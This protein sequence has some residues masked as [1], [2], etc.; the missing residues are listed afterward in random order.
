MTRIKKNTALV[1]VTVILFFTSAYISF[2]QRPTPSDFQQQAAQQAP[3]QGGQASQKAVFVPLSGLQLTSGQ[4]PSLIGY[5]NTI[6]T[7][8]ITI[9]AMLSVIF[10]AIAGVKYMSSDNIGTKESAKNDIWSCLVGLVLILGSVII[11]QV[12]NPC[13]LNFD[14]LRG[15]NS[16]TGACNVSQ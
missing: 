1:S 12:I 2:A 16:T 7:V 11:L 5:L 10:I 3:Q 6:F 4:T 14:V 8:L 13:I 15:S 9:S